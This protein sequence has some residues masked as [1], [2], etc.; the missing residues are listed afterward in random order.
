MEP[1]Y[2]LS[3]GS[4]TYPQNL[5]ELM[6]SL[7]LLG[8]PISEV[9]SEE[10]IDFMMHHPSIASS[11][12]KRTFI[13]ELR[14]AVRDEGLENEPFLSRIPIGAWQEWAKKWSKNRWTEPFK[15]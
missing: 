9:R 1:F 6:D 8:I 4:E 7:L 3:V 15:D 14:R 5:T 13:T 10:Y 2:E 12:A 11:I